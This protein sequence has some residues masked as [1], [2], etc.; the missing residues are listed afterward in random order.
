[1][2]MYK[3]ADAELVVDLFNEY[4]HKLFYFNQSLRIQK[5]DGVTLL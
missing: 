2:C 1:M 4:E 3:N 5:A